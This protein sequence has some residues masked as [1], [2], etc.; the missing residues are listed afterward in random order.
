M[1]KI[2]KRGGVYGENVCYYAGVVW[3]RVSEVRTDGSAYERG[4]FRLCKRLSGKQSKF[5]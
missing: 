4:E 3:F 1:L 2:G 5:G